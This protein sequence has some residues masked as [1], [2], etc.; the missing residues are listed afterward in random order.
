MLHTNECLFVGDSRF[1]SVAPAARDG[2]IVNSW[3]ESGLQISRLV[4]FVNEK[5]TPETNLLV[6]GGFLCDLTYRMKRPNN[7]KGLMRTNLTPPWEEILNKVTANTAYWE[8]TFGL[9]VIWT[10]PYP[11]N[12]VRYNEKIAVKCGQPDGLV[13]V[14]NEEAWRDQELLEQHLETLKE[15]CR[16]R[17]VP[18][19]DLKK[20]HR[21][22]T[23]SKCD[24]VHLE[25]TNRKQVL[26]QTIEAATISYP[27]A[28][29]PVAGRVRSEEGKMK[30]K[31]RQKRRRQNSAAKRRTERIEERWQDDRG[32][33]QA[34]RPRNDYYVPRQHFVEP[35][36]DPGVDTPR[37]RQ[38]YSRVWNSPGQRY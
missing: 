1:H 5:L 4:E 22:M 31:L 6:L 3:T 30:T 2:W 17:R 14:Q 18:L 32:Q 37:S 35:R 26:D 36:N 29:L 7:D 27:F 23:H 13:P 8:R 24:G 33:R 19:Y 9:S 21:N 10:L 20:L 12:V 16:E 34:K 11:V 25:K 15:K 28:I 38:R